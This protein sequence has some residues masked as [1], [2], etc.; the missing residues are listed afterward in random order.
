MAPRIVP[1]PNAAACVAPGP[2]LYALRIGERWQRINRVSHREP[3]H[4]D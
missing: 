1:R 2:L 3:P 4:T